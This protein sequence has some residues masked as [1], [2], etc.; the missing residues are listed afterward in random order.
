MFSS[1][2]FYVIQHLSLFDSDVFHEI[3]PDGPKKYV[4]S[5]RHHFGVKMPL[6]LLL[7][8]LPADGV[9]GSGFGR[10]AQSLVPMFPNV[11]M[12]QLTV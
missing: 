9:A 8:S 12:E 2:G 10:V 7:K 11:S 1:V 3:L 4:T 6:R 5:C